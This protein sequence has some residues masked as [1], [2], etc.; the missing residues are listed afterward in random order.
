M[1]W[2]GFD[3][4][5]VWQKAAW[6]TSV[7]PICGN[8][9]LPRHRE[10]KSRRYFLKPDIKK[11]ATFLDALASLDFKLS[12]SQ[13]FTFFLQLAHLRVFQI[14]LC[15]RTIFTFANQKPKKGKGRLIFLKNRV[16]CHNCAFKADKKEMQIVLQ[17]VGRS[18]QGQTAGQQKQTLVT[19][20]NFEELS[21][22]TLL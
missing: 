20:L 2:N 10:E 8:A 14:Y 15:T 9:W 18:G 5:R 1:K 21:D 13:R 11:E 7:G 17:N 6:Q 4:K 16:I 3:W 12:L 22:E 19:L